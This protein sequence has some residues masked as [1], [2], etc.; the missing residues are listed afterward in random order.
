MVLPNFNN[1]DLFPQAQNTI[2]AFQVQ[3]KQSLTGNSKNK[4]A[5]GN[6]VEETADKE[7]NL[8]PMRIYVA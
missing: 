1:Q 5:D 3:P 7:S 6:K 8:S 4:N 2:S